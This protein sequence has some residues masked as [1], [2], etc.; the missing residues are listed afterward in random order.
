[1]PSALV[2]PKESK[3]EQR[4]RLRVAKEDAK[5][6]NGHCKHG[7][8]FP[9]NFLGEASCKRGW[10]GRKLALWLLSEPAKVPG[11]RDPLKK[12]VDAARNPVA[13]P[14]PATLL[15]HVWIALVAALALA[16]ALCEQ[17]A[18]T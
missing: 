10:Q 18:A 13:N 16:C 12:R 7:H 8:H 5:K 6:R 1:M 15:N 4:H 3:R 2:Q 11:R 17:S 14:A 9:G